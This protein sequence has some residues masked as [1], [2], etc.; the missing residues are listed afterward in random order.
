MALAPSRRYANWIL[1]SARWDDFPFRPDDIV[2]SAPPKCGTT[3]MQ[4]ICAL[5]IF[6]SSDFP[7]RLGELSPCLDS[8]TDSAQRV[9]SLLDAQA[10]R[11]FIKTHTPL[12]G[13]PYRPE[14]TYLCVGRD[15]RDVVVSFHHQLQNTNFRRVIDVVDVNA[16]L[17]DF[18][19]RRS[20]S[21]EPLDLAGTFWSFVE[22]EGLAERAH[23]SGPSSVDPFAN[24]AALMAH[25]GTFWGRR[26]LPN[27]HLFH[28]ADLQ[29]DL[30]GQM[31]RL[32]SVLRHDVAEA[33]W[34]GLVAAAGFDSMRARSDE[35]V[36][37]V[38][39]D[40]HWLDNARFFNRGSNG[41]W[42]QVLTTP[43]DRRRYEAAVTRWGDAA[44]LAWAHGGSMGHDRS[45]WDG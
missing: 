25:L 29:A 34:P 22:G 13:I 3:W 44:F 16:G 38:H 1:D 43:E 36:P 12:D 9:R 23:R 41:Q 35:L 37:E 14:V 32:A 17:D 10:Q 40:G 24:L 11:R 5:L 4:T 42:R 21:P 45:W 39:V 19:E 26:D 28:Y 7:A 18:P 30:D 8:K 27:V 6:G 15:P 31:R 20:S 2:I 33:A